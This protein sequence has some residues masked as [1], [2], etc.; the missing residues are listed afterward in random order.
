MSGRERTPQQVDPLGALSARPVTVLAALA[1]LV[2]AGVMTTTTRMEIASPGATAGAI[3]ALVAA[4]VVLVLS[5]SP[6]RAPFRRRSLV[7]LSVLSAGAVVL[8]AVGTAGRDAFVR[9]DW[10]P[11]AV[12][13]LLLALAPYRPGVEI[14][15]AGLGVALVVAVVVV[16]QSPSFVTPVPVTSF[17]VVAVTPVLALAFA[18]A[19][20]SRTFTR[21]VEEWDA[22]ASVARS[23]SAEELTESVARSVQQDR[24]TVLNRDVVP[25]FTSLVASGTVEEADVERA[26]RIAD[27][28]RSTMVAEA[29]RSWLEHLFA[30]DGAPV[31][32]VV[33]DP[34]R[35]AP[36]MTGEHRTAVRALLVALGASDTV[37][38]DDVQVVLRERDGRVDG[39][40]SVP[41]A[42]G[43][44][45]V[46][47][48]LAPWLAVLR[49][50]F[51]D[52]Q[53]DPSP[54]LLTLRFSYDQH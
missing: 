1:A 6:Y 37:R 8:S 10:P 19:A 15:L 46:R 31:S 27:S 3:V 14:A 52:L 50:V 53:V 26:R 17:V 33:V 18:G 38:A 47:H 11:V 39:V 32:G 22:R 9:D 48:A 4:G 49:V 51:G 23:A 21:L 43:E 5:A 20:F 29:D 41:V 13:V 34:D 54:P 30:G 2:F 44:A 7:A 42:G 36:A 24:V 16:V 45:S 25:F 28:L 40:L 12:G 35:L